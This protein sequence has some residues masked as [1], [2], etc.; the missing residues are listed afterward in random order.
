MLEEEIELKNETIRILRDRWAVI[1]I[2]GFA[3]GCLY[4][5]FMQ[6][7]FGKF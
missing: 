7:I 6:I 5:G 3:F 2:L 1:F 4:M